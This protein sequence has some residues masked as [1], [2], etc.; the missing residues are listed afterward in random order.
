VRVLLLLLLR[1]SPEQGA[2]EEEPAFQPVLRF[3]TVCLSLQLTLL[4][5]E[6][7]TLRN[8]A[9][10]RAQRQVVEEAPR[11]QVVLHWS[12]GTSA[13]DA[14]VCLLRIF[15]RKFELTSTVG[16]QAFLVALMATT[17]GTWG[18]WTDYKGESAALLLLADFVSLGFDTSACAMNS[19]DGRHV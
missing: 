15:E 17:L 1:R 2:P 4:C 18:Y 19:R 7:L 10:A 13:F 14:F 11:H 8:V 16:S 5:S 12:H 6:S 9:C 3:V